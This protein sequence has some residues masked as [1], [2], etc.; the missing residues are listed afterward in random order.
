MSQS[1]TIIPVETVSRPKSAKK[2]RS[3]TLRRLVQQ[4]RETLRE[5]GVSFKIRHNAN[6][7]E[8]IP[9]GLRGHGERSVIEDIW[10]TSTGTEPKIGTDTPDGSSPEGFFMGAKQCHGWTLCELEIDDKQLGEILKFNGKSICS[11]KDT[12]DGNVGAYYALRNAL[13]QAGIDPRAIF[14]N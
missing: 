11:A 6:P 14:K 2:F 9:A 3:L 5:R 10:F 12:Y 4:A 7:V 8:E 1:A 13:L